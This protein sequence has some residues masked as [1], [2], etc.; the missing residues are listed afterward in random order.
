MAA[1]GLAES[2]ARDAQRRRQR[3]D[4]RPR[5]RPKSTSSSRRPA[6]AATARPP[7][8][9]AELYVII[10]LPKKSHRHRRP[11]CRCA[12]SSR[13]RLQVR[14]EVLDRRG[15]DVPVR[16]QRSRSSAAAPAV[17]SSGLTVGDTIVSGQNTLA[18][19]RHLRGRR[20]RRRNRDLVRRARA[21][22]RL[23]PRQHAISRVLARLDSPDVVRHVPRL[24]DRQPAAQRAGP[25]R[26]RVL[27]GSS[28]RR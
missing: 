23:S 12:A 24:A 16:H 22:G 5:R 21:A 26:E 14:D 17:S 4:Q 19:R 1:V 20:R 8:A 13:R 9:S 6:S 15:P 18:G 11:T 27:R 25:A 28:R 10:D 3:D 7:L 2:R